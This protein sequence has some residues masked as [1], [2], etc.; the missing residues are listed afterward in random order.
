[1][2][3]HVANLRT[4]LAAGTDDE[5]AWLAGYLSF[6]DASA[7]YRHLGNSDGR[8]HMF[9]ELNATFPTGFVPLVRKAGAAAGYVVEILD[10]RTVPCPWDGLAD[11]G[12]LRDY[13][14]AG[15]HAVRDKGRGILW[16]PTGSGKTEVFAALTRALACRWLFV[17]H[18]TNLVDQAA[19]RVELRTGERVGRIGEGAWTDFTQ[20]RIVCATFQS[21]ARG[22]AGGDPATRALLLGAEGLVVDEAHTTPAASFLK[23]VMSAPNAYYR[24]GLSGTPLARGDRRSVLAV[25]AL[26]SVIYRIRTDTL[27]EAG[28]LAR[29]TIRMI[30]VRQA[31]ECPT[32]QG[33]YGA[34]IVR[35]TAR[36]RALVDA[37]VRVPK[38]CLVFVKELAHGRA[39]EKLLGR[40][41]VNARFVWGT[42]PLDARKR[43]VRDLVAGRIDALVCSVIFQEGID[44][45]ELR[46]VVIASAGK[47]AIAALQRI[48]RG[49]RVEKDAAG[50]VI[51]G[52]FEVVDVADVGCG[53]PKKARHTG[54]RWLEAHT[55]A[56]LRAYVGE[57]H[58][59]TREQPGLTLA[60]GAS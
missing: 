19:E 31:V 59:V 1:V 42:H 16:C 44:I 41:G 55:A 25:A 8:I 47:S 30:E 33:V 28:V 27:V 43:M 23:V 4:K 45:P 21:L 11:L 3:L 38:P 26:G 29:P 34:A 20:Y 7:K 54:C 18:R 9:H 49:M 60:G 12:W 46:S 48:G 50:Q 37:V 24:V 5:R 39:L 22:L 52:T 53:C 14:L 32:W 58:S 17:V 2:I 40:A 10:T 6:E 15:A 56:R 51:K 57:G 13:Q 36:N 35:S